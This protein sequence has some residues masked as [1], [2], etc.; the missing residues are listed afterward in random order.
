MGG[1]YVRI[2]MGEDGNPQGVEGGGRV[3]TGLKGGDGR[4][5]R[6]VPPIMAMC[7]GSSYVLGNTPA[8]VDDVVP[9]RGRS[10]KPRWEM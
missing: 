3:A 10:L 8:I 1:A 7:T 5:P 6:P 2:D 9:I 4:D